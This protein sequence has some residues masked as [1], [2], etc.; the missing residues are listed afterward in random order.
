MWYKNSIGGKN[1]KCKARL[2]LT[3]HDINKINTTFHQKNKNE[4]TN[5]ANSN[6]FNHSYT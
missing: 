3:K 1:N 6:A 5:S 4:K 2:M